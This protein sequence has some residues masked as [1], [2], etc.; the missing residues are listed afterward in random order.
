MSEHFSFV[1]LA[2]KLV[3]QRGCK[4]LCVEVRA[5]AKI[6]SA[7]RSADQLHQ[8][9]QMMTLKIICYRRRFEGV[10]TDYSKINKAMKAIQR[11]L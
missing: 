2:W 1:L 5:R 3:P 6:N 10:C 8:R 9:G 7:A 4:V 11:H